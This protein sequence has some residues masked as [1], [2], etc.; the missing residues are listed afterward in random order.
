MSKSSSTKSV[1]RTLNSE[2]KD[3]IKKSVKKVVEKVAVPETVV[4]E[5]KAVKKSKVSTKSA[6]SSEAKPVVEKKT[7]AKGSSTKAPKKEK[8]VAEPVPE[9]VASHQAE[10]GEDVKT[11]RRREVTNESVSQ[12]FDSILEVLREN[13]EQSRS[14]GAKKGTNVKLL[15]QLGKRLKLLKVD[16]M[17]ISKQRRTKRKNNNSA[18][19]MKPVKISDE[20]AKF[21][22]WDPQQLRTRN[23]VTRYVCDYIRDNNLQNPDD[24]RKINPDSKLSKLLDYSA[25]GENPMYYYTIQQRIQKH[26]SKPE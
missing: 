9:V 15:R 16:C 7:S 26:Y 24:R 14:A 21:T 23:D 10:S 2:V 1:T 12:E 4:E 25:S 3:K 22:G 11:K 20:L 18:G 19:F 17:R 5:V 13:V 6:T 8:T